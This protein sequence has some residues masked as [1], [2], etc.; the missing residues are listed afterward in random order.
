MRV[1]R[2]I[3]CSLLMITAI[4]TLYCCTKGIIVK[5]IITVGERQGSTTSCILFIIY[6]NEFMK[7]LQEQ[8]PPDGLQLLY[9]LL[10]M[11]DSVVTN[12]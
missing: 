8:S 11:D 10:L 6:L 3:G 5:A 1:L 7:R 4:A 2:N 12:I 9:C